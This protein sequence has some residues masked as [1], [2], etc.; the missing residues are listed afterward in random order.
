MSSFWRNRFRS[1]EV[2]VGPAL[3]PTVGLAV[4]AVFLQ[5]MFAPFVRFHGAVPSLVTI[6]VVLYAAK[7]GARRGAVF[8]II[9]GLLEDCFAGTGGAWT[10][11]TTVTALAVGAISRTFFSD[12]FAMLAA[13]VAIAILLR[14]TVFWAVMSLEGYPRGFALAHAHAALWQAAITGACTLLYLIVRS[15][16]IDDR[17]TVERYP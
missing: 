14:D 8:G 11:A 5:T 4:L 7:V 2:V 12:G 9:A 3:G 10:I 6:S 17:M 13:L 16:F 15:R 1:V